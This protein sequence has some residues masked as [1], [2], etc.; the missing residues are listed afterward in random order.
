[1]ELQNHEMKC[2]VFGSCSTK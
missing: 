2:E 1:M